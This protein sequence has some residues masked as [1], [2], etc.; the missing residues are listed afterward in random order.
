MSSTAMPT[1]EERTEAR[2]DQLY[3]M[4]DDLETIANSDA[5]Y[6]DYARAALQRLR[7]AGYD[8]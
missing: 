1:V 6:A 3:E 2:L 8:V 5:E 7:Q 4:R